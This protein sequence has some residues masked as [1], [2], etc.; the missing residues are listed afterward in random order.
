V[1]RASAGE[2]Q[3]EAP[4]TIGYARVSTE[5]QSANGQSLA[6]QEQQLRG[7]AQMT[8]RSIDTVV[9]EAG[10]SGGVPF[11]QRPEG[12]KL[13]AELRRGDNLVVAKL[14][15]FSR[16]L[17]D[18]LQVSRELQK[19]GVNLFLLDVGA[20]DPVTGNGQSKLFLSML[21]AFS[22]FERDRISERI[23]A[24]KQRQKARGEFSGGVAPY[25]WVYDAG[26]LVAVPEQQRTITRI[27]Q[28][29]RRGLSPYRIS[30]D[31]AL[32]GVKLS[33]VTVR[34]IIAGRAAP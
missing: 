5:E 1:R 6:V 4:R 32:R 29:A 31:L 20:A 18:C 2:P 26:K 3:A 23:K 33:H 13:W 34:K 9:I 14:D 12:G 28:L 25:G 16:N 17:F 8:E 22:E 15:R 27:R 24:T 19:R 11:I 21:G 30:A 7:W 10:V